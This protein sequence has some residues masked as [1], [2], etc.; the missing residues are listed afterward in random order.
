MFLH[1]Q[2][3][4]IPDIWNFDLKLDLLQSNIYWDQILFV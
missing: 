3:I 4:E 1:F 2:F